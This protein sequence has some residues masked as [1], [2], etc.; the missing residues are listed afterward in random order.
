MIEGISV[1]GRRL[2]QPARMAD[3][4]EIVD[5]VATVRDAETN[6]DELAFQWTAT[7]GTFSGTTASR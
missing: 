1:Q 4:G 2:L 7:A 3:L 5:V 6:A